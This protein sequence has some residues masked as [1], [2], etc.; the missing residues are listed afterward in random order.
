M[1]ETP[2]EARH[3]YTHVI[4]WKRNRQSLYKTI[5]LWLQGRYINNI[6]FAWTHGEEEISKFFEHSNNFHANLTL[7][8]GCPTQKIDVHVTVKLN[9]NHLVADNV[10]RPE[11]ATNILI[12]TLVT[13]ISQGFSFVG[14]I[15]LKVRLLKRYH[16]LEKNKKKIFFY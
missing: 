12:I 11:I 5:K 10:Y 14:R 6:L 16:K 2:I 4:L 15:I 7:V 3:L 13:H 9:N 1:P 8:L